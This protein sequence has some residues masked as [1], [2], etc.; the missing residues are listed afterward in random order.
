[1]LGEIGLDHR[2]VEDESQY[3]AQAEVFEFLL[4]EASR[5]DRSVNLHTT[6]AEQEVLEALDRHG[7][8]RVIVH[9]YSGPLNILE[10]LVERGS[11]FAMG[12]GVAHH[13]HVR[14]LAAAIPADRLL[15]ETDNPGGPEWLTG[16]RG[17]PGLLQD[18]VRALA[19]VR[20]TTAEEVEATV[21]RNF[22]RFV[23]AD[24]HLTA[25]CGALLE[26]SR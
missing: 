17:M 10:A 22:R 19:E 16:T 9:W 18:A 4:S 25:A 14:D 5:G 23:E 13:E 1:M 3:P 8:E 7:I 24:P 21:E 6:G 12:I 20:G 15:T 2:F 26:G 11:Y